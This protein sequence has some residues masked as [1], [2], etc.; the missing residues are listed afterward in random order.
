MRICVHV[1]CVL[2]TMH[3]ALIWVWV[4][5]LFAA[6]PSHVETV[7]SSNY[8]TTCTNDNN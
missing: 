7:S 8:L 6:S 4:R 5:I 1:G 2:P 3:E